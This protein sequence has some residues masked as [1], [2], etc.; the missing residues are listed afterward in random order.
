MKTEMIFKD[1]TESQLP[2]KSD[3]KIS[4]PQRLWELDNKFLYKH[5]TLW[6]VVVH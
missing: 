5:P 4:R 6:D 1:H 3:L 2:W